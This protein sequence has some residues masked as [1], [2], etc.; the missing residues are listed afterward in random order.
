MLLSRLV[1]LTAISA[2]RSVI[3]SDV[4]HPVSLEYHSEYLIDINFNPLNYRHML[5]VQLS[6]FVDQT[7]LCRVITPMMA[8]PATRGHHCLAVSGS[9]S[10]TRSRGRGPLLSSTARGTTV[11]Q[12]SPGDKKK[13]VFFHLIEQVRRNNHLFFCSYSFMRA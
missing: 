10:S 4:T 12:R 3:L 8:A 11:D 13:K 6:A 9:I 5:S 7:V 1:Y 2:S